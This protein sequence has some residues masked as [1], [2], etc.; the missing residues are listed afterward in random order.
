MVSATNPGAKAQ[1]LLVEDD[2]RMRAFLA[3]ELACEGYGVEEAADGQSALVH[4]RSQPPDLVL[5]DWNLPDFSGV[6]ICRR[7][8]ASGVCTPVLMITGH[9]DVRD[10]V[11]ALDSGADD[12]LLKP[13]S[14]EELLAR[15]RALLR[16]AAF[17][18]TIAGA[19]VLSVADLS[20]NTATREVERGGVP[21]ALT[22]RE[23]D[24]LLCL[25]RRAG[26]VV[27]REEILREV[28]GEHPCGAENLLWVYVRYLRRKIE[29]VGRP[30]LIQTV[31]GVG[32]MLREGEMRSSV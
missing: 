27:E 20:L 28:W 11:E 14:I 31:R 16:R 3:G 2:V 23:Y 22:V 29:P 4:L 15:V 32:L 5:L 18:R 25:L 17:G 6:E 10:R 19:E 1:L 30:T 8:R 9:D 12:Y 7:L 26:R 24:L 13:F 21:V